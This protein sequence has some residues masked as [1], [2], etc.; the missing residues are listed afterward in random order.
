MMHMVA[1][2]RDVYEANPSI[3]GSLF[4]AFEEAKQVALRHMRHQAALRYM[5]PWMNAEMEEMKD[6]FGD[7]P[8]PYG[9]EAN[10]HALET[11]MGYMTE[12]GIIARPVPVEALFAPLD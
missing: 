10:R 7:D 6:L 12:Q 3:A 2:R 1:I 8:Y 4:R 9:V 5:L 11:M